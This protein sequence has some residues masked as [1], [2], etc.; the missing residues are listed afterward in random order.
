MI[1]LHRLALQL[2]EFDVDA[3]AERLTLQQFQSWVAYYLIEPFG[4][5]WRRSARLAVWQAA[6]MGAKV[7]EDDQLEEK[8]LPTFSKVPQTDKEIQSEFAK[9]E[10]FKK[11]IE[12]NRKS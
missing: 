5:D 3:L 10:A 2:G 6:S 8:F 1:F 7:N 12:Q 4:N 9:I 11:M